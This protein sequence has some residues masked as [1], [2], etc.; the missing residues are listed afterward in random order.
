MCAH[1]TRRSFPSA[2]TAMRSRDFLATDSEYAG[3]PVLAE[4]ARWEW[5]MTEVF[6]AADADSVGVSDL[7][8]VAPEEWAEL[9]FE[10]HP[11]VRPAGA[12]PGMRRRYGRRSADGAERAGKSSLQ[13]GAGA[14]AAVAAGA[15]DLFSLAAAWRGEALEAAREGQSFGELCALLCG[16]FRRGAGA[17]EGGGFLAGL[18]GVRAADCGCAEAGRAPPG[19]V[20]AYNPR[21]KERMTP[22]PCVITTLQQRAGDDRPHAARR[23]HSYRYRVRAGYFSSSRTRIPAAP[24]RTASGCI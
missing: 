9:R 15:A 5:A 22:K 2:I 4:L 24:S 3:A 1:M 11:S 16:G 19:A 18:G 8:S 23:R 12:C 6:D 7:A 13:P 20:L 21:E 10:L 17:C 14:V